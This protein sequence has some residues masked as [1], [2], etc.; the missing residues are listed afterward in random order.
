[1]LSTV[2]AM[3]L[4]RTSLGHLKIKAIF[5]ISIIFWLYMI[6]VFEH[7]MHMSL[8]CGVPASYLPEG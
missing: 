4:G 2:Y 1:M 7:E 5:V 3:V 8:V 6:D